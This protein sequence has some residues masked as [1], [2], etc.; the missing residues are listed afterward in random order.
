MLLK[1][2]F[3]KLDKSLLDKYEEHGNVALLDAIALTKREGASVIAEGVETKKQLEIL[4]TLNV[5]FIQGYYFGKPKVLI[6]RAMT[7]VTN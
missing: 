1:P 7:K 4:A 5:D 3:I 2:D 6:K